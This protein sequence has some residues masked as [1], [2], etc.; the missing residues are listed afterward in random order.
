MQEELKKLRIKIDSIDDNI[1]NLLKERVEIVKEVGHLKAK[2]IGGTQ[3]FIRSG[4]EAD[5]LR[6]LT[7]KIEGKLPKAAIATIWRVIISSS[8]AIEQDMRIKAYVESNNESC[9]WLAREYY[10]SFVDIEKISKTNDIIKQISENASYVGILPL[11]DNE[12]NPWWIRPDDE[13]NDIYIFAKV[14]F[15]EN[16]KDDI[17]PVLAIANVRPEKTE[18]DAS[19]IAIKKCNK[20]Q[21]NK[22][23]S[24]LK[25]KYNILA[26]SKNSDILLEILDYLEPDDKRV[27]AL[28]DALP[29]ARLL[30]S[31][32]LPIMI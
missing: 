29:N 27:I 1:I 28:K 10:G 2:N 4:R 19:I 24:G 25:L 6:S 13:K 16:K 22:I 20:E 11:I 32:A 30:G 18:G 7:N 8:L 3:N 14:P 21:V 12:K 9:Y 23:L 17:N 31:Y 26:E 15:I 5:M